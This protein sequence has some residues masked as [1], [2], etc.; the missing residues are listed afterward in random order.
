MS[1][2]LMTQSLLSAWLYIY[3]AREDKEEEA[4]D[5]FLRVLNRE[6]TETTKAMQKGIDFEDAVTAYLKGGEA[7]G[8]VKTVG[9]MIRGAVLQVP[10]YLDRTIDGMDFLLYGRID[11]LKA[12]VIYDIKYSESYETNKYLDSPQHP[13][14]LEC[15]PSAREFRYLISDGKEV[16]VERYTRS[17]TP[18]VDNVIRQFMSFLDQY[19]LRDIY[20]SKWQTW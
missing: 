5:S 12:G 1:K 15:L 9:D 20:I 10:V 3:K 8:T 14:Y 18:S 6:P 19:G 7:D 4:Y 17:E 11:A 2:Y 13:I 16:Y